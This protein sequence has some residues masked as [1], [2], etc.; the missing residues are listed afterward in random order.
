MQN[1]VCIA[2]T[3]YL[4][5]RVVTTSAL[6]AWKKANHQH[7]RMWP[8]WMEERLPLFDAVIVRGDWE[9]PHAAQH[10]QG[11]EY[12]VQMRGR[13]APLRPDTH[14]VARHWVLH[15]PR[16]AAQVSE[17]GPD[18]RFTRQLVTDFQLT[19]AALAEAASR[20]C[21]LPPITGNTSIA[22]RGQWRTVGASGR[23]RGAHSQRRA[24]AAPI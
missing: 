11:R 5:V 18:A 20:R 16:T 19:E 6:E 3:D 10:V 8:H 12:R 9:H 15:T 13:I 4:L 24:V 22:T 21:R 1:E 7:E 17:L 23:S 14:L 2:P